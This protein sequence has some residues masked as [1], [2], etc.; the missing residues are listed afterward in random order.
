MLSDLIT[1]GTVVYG[2]PLLAPLFEPLLAPVDIALFRYKKFFL[3]APP[4]FY[5]RV[6][7]FIF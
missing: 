3:A 7:I 1:G 5:E 2:T 6:P 4:E